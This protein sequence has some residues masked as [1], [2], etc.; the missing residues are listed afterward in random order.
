MNIK[1]RHHYDEIKK[2][3]ES[4]EYF[5]NNYIKTHNPTKEV[6]SLTL[7]DFQKRYI[8]HLE[9]NRFS[10]CTKFR[11]GGFTTITIAYLLWKFIFQKDLSIMVVSKTDQEVWAI[12]ELFTK[13]HNSLPDW[14]QTLFESNSSNYKKSLET[15]CKIMFRKPEHES[16][17][18][19]ALDILFIDEAAFIED[20][21][22]YWKALWPCLST[23][24]R[25]IVVSTP[26]KEDGWFYDMYHQ[27]L[28]GEN[29]FSVFMSDYTECPFWDEEKI[30]II[31]VNLGELGFQQ[32]IEQKF[33]SNVKK[34]FK[35]MKFMD[36]KDSN[37]PVNLL[38]DDFS[39]QSYMK[40]DDIPQG[41]KTSI[42]EVDKINLR[43]G[44]SFKCD[45]MKDLVKAFPDI[46]CDKKFNVDHPQMNDEFDMSSK[47][48][49]ELFEGLAKDDNGY[50]DAAKFWRENY[51]YWES[52][53][54]EIESKIHGVFPADILRLAGVINKKE[55]KEIDESSS[56]GKADVLRAIVEDDRFP[57]SLK[58]SFGPYLEV[59]GVPTLITTN[60]IKNAYMGLAALWSHDE[61]VAFVA[62]ILKEKLDVLFGFG[63][64]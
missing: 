12:S 10:V 18:G 42:E 43:E 39:F 45:Y 41:L 24:G 40:E 57:K 22:S 46:P 17:R 34:E 7:H 61:A 44:Y 58:L 20:M 6:L 5:A 47:N 23:D 1:N 54:E 36:I 14:L 31:R 28:N 55:E 21:D 48:L 15:G 62:N 35:K 53:Q 29:F 33:I 38:Y 52:K 19:H 64:E 16:V 50:E 8:S 26:N 32:E 49:A 30:K 25:A 56:T 60:S 11:Q 2:C 37:K 63:K 4:F 27:A 3:A 59:N 51:N 13:M 9:E